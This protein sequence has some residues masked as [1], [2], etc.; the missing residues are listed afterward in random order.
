MDCV[1]HAGIISLR[2]LLDDQNLTIV[3]AQATYKSRYSTYI[4]IARCRDN[5]CEILIELLVD[6][7]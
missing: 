5:V 4:G 7:S 2:E 1:L 3:T 6:N